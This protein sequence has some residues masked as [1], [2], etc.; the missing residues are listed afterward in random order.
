M[1]YRPQSILLVDDE[2]SMRRTLSE[3]L[4]LEG[5]NVTTACDG[6]EAIGK[7]HQNSQNDNSDPYDLVILDLKMPGLDGLDVLKFIHQ[8]FPKIQV[9][10]LT[11]HGSLQSAIEALRY[12]AH[13]YILKPATPEYVIDSVNRGLK[14]HSEQRQREAIISQLETSIHALRE[15]Y[16]LQTKP[17]RTGAT[18]SVRPTGTSTLLPM[19][20]EGWIDV[21]HRRIH[22][23]SI[24][25]PLSPT[26]AKLLVLWI[27]N[28]GKVFSCQELVASL[29]GFDATSR[30]ASGLIRPIISRLRRKF[31]IL[32]SGSKWIINVRSNGYTLEIAPNS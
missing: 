25:I 23:G 21:D 22:W 8:E 9:I 12:G 29:H 13:D 18:T 24:D 1:N 17:K 10:L 20:E 14:R 2:D 6:N 19:G 16:P 4:H 27:Q 30:E 32:P 28:P 3:L 26:E 31:S 11:A 7:L 5:Y 15:N